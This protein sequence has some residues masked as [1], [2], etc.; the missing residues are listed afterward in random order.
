MVSTESRSVSHIDILKASQT[1]AR[2]GQYLYCLSAKENDEIPVYWSQRG[3]GTTFGIDADV[4]ISKAM[5]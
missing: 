2:H 1:S 3:S 4:P 5:F